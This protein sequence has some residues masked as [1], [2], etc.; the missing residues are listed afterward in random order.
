MTATRSLHNT[1]INRMVHH[2][3]MTFKQLEARN[4]H[5]AKSSGVIEATK[6]ASTTADP[7]CRPF[8]RSYA[9]YIYNMAM[10]RRQSAAIGADD[11]SWHCHWMVLWN[12]K[13]RAFFFNIEIFPG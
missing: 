6:N 11:T 4:D 5:D 2:F 7:C 9:R 13:S 1:T 3:A 10:R 12:G 8:V